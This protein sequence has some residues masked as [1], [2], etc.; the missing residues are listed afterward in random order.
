LTKPA[1]SSGTFPMGITLTTP[2]HSRSH[3]QTA[4]RRL[5]RSGVRG[6]CLAI[7]PWSGLIFPKAEYRSSTIGPTTQVRSKWRGVIHAHLSPTAETGCHGAAHMGVWITSA[8][9]CWGACVRPAASTCSS[10]SHA[11]KSTFHR[12]LHLLLLSLSAM[13]SNPRQRVSGV[14][15][16]PDGI[17]ALARKSELFFAQLLPLLRA[18]VFGHDPRL[19]TD[20]TRESM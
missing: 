2:A 8:T 1:V 7:R 15:P 10:T 14:S 11:G 20:T 6:K 16:Y 5:S 18:E 12:C 4:A 13:L 17:F 9:K 19:S 3:L